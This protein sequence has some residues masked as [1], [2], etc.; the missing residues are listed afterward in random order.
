MVTFL[1][2][3][4]KG[5][6]DAVERVFPYSPHHFFV[7]HAYKNFQKKHLGGILKSQF[8]EAARTYAKHG[9]TKALL[10]QWKKLKLLSLEAHQ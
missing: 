5:L 10:R 9:F 7:R 3:R 1:S 4:Q 8:W 6:V 2:D